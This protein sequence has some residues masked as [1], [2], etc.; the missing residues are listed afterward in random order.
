[1]LTRDVA[2]KL[3]TVKHVESVFGDF[4]DQPIKCAPVKTQVKED[5]TPYRVHTTRRISIPIPEKVKDELMRINNSGWIAKVTESTDWCST[6]VPLMKGSGAVK[7]CTDLKKLNL[8]V[9][10]ERYVIPTFEDML[11]KIKSASVQQSRCHQRIL[12]YT[13]GREYCQT[14]HVHNA[15]WSVFLP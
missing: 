11:H 15:L 3:G 5:R 12:A 13:Y 10:K 6:I 7:I 8:A 1:M 9:R 14:D 2:S 4:D